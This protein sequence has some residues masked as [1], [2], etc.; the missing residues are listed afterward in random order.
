[1][2]EHPKICI[3]ATT[4]NVSAGEWITTCLTGGEYEIT[5]S[6]E[7]ADLIICLSFEANG[8]LGLF[9]EFPFVLRQKTIVLV[10]EYDAE[11]IRQLLKR[12]GGFFDCQRRPVSK[13]IILAVVNKALKELETLKALQTQTASAT[14]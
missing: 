2:S 11:T 13:S 1:M 3:L 5:K 7:E 8:A 6:K 9:E 10:L 12:S 14:Q 4:D